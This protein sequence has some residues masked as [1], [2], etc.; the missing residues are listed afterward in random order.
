MA[1]QMRASGATPA[2]PFGALG[3]MGGM[4]G[5]GGQFPPFGA[6]A[7]TPTSPGAGAGASA[8]GSLP[9]G[10]PLPGAPATNANPFGMVDPNMLMSIMGGM[11]GA[12]P[13]AG[14]A[15]ASSGAP[16]SPVASGPPPEERFQT[17]LQQLSD[18]G[19]SNARQNIRALLATGGNVNGAIEY[20]FGGGGI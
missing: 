3:G 17:Q 6:F 15:G 7:Q 2:N 19:F 12:A 9:S 18:M 11:G 1:S 8:T 10:A 13:W 5:Q 16:I 14:G 20:I 4:G